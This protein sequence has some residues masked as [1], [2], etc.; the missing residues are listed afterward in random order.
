MRFRWLAAA[1]AALLSLQVAQAQINLTSRATQS[2]LSQM[3]SEC[4]TLG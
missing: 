3:R 1:F 4:G 2:A